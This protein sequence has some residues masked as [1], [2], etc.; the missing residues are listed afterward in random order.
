MDAQQYYIRGVASV[1]QG[2][3]VNGRKQLLQSLK[4]EPNNDKAWLWISRT[5]AD[6]DKKLECAERALAINP[7]NRDA[8]RLKQQLTQQNKPKRAK[9]DQQRIRKLMQEAD[10][11]VKTNRKPEA[12]DKWV[13]VLDIQHDHETA[14]KHAVEYLAARDL[15][16]DVRVLLYNAV[17][18]G[19]DNAMIL[20][21]ARD[22][23]RTEATLTRYDELC[24]M[25]SG[26]EWVTPKQV[27][28]MANDYAKDRHYDNAVRIL[29][30]GLKVHIDE[31]E[32][33]H[34]MAQVH[35]A[36]GRDTLALQ[37]Y[38]RVANSAVRSK[39]G[40]EADKRLSQAVPIMSDQ[41]RGSAAFAWREVFGIF[42]LFFLFA[43]QDAGLNVLDM[44]AN[45]WMGV[46]LSLVGSYLL[47]T[48]T[49]S[50][51]QQPLARILGGRLPENNPKTPERRMNPFAELLASLG[52][53]IDPE[54]FH[55]GPIHEPS[56]LP[57]IPEWIR[58]VFGITGALMLVFAFYLVL[59]TAIG[60]L[61]L[62]ELYLDPIYYEAMGEF[63]R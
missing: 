9:N 18:L 33:L 49:S 37:Y 13:M 53:Q 45:R 29:Q 63:L 28:S 51:Q 24:V 58:W 40:K 41:E 10:M 42:I 48:A 14:M 30:N 23:A 7:N 5:I 4:L 50:P 12:V 54:N 44:G 27:L 25:I 16:D 56:R 8:Q 15:M 22:L 32:L 34:K 2:D 36:T 21:S 39:I 60:L 20:L 52:M 47:V 17:D 59:T 6:T 26:A 57:V 55:V 43:F 46:I 38:E 19:T 35:E 62:Q 11:L 1:K 3:M 31:P 61:G